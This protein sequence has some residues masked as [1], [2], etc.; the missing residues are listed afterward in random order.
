MILFIT[1]TDES[2]KSNLS[3]AGH[4]AATSTIPL[5]EATAVRPNILAALAG[6]P[7]TPLFALCHGGRDHIVGQDAAA[8]V[9][10][11]DAALLGARESFALA[12]YTS[13]EL[14]PAVA[15]AGGTWFGYS[16]PVS[17]LFDDLD[18]LDHFTSVA[19]FIAQ[20]F[21]G[22]TTQAAATAFIAGLDAVADAAF[23]AI[24]A[25]GVGD[26][27]KFHALRDITRRLRIWLP[28]EADPVK[29]PDATPEPLL[30]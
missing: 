3:V 1:A 24:D 11:G 19:E 7:A 2:T 4:L 22:C 30:Y 17:C 28:A 12:C 27:G 15:N 20:Q 8:A 25:A 29:H 18:T 9:G 10:V 21:V 23:T 6:A 14:G 5:C 16:G 26:M 13:A